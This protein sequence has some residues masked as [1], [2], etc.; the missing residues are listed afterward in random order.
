MKKHFLFICLCAILLLCAACG[1][2]DT[3]Y[4]DNPT[5]GDAEKREYQSFSSSIDVFD[6]YMELQITP[7]ADP[8]GKYCYEKHPTITLEYL[9]EGKWTAND[10]EKG[11]LRQTIY[12]PPRYTNSTAEMILER[13]LYFPYS[14]DRM[15]IPTGNA[16]V[17]QLRCAG[18]DIVVCREDEILTLRWFDENI[19]YRLQA[20]ISIEELLLVI[21]GMVITP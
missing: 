2:N 14:C 18:K 3:I 20:T 19:F 4:S 9:P 12:K 5:E 7:A 8:L 21:E 6:E 11:N 17:E 1:S 16:T 10:Y 13:T 15:L